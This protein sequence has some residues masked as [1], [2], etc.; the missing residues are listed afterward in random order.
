MT[1]LSV[2]RDVCATVG[3]LVPSSVFTNITGN[4]TMIEMA[5]L[6]NDM[7]QRIAFETRDWSKL[8]ATV[9]YTGDGVTTAFD[10]PVNYKRMLLT[11][12]VWKSTTA[13]YPMR[14]IPDLDQWLQRR[15]LDNYDPYGEWTIVGNQ[16]FI[17]P[18]MAGPISSNPA[19]T[20]YFAYLRNG[21]VNLTSGGFGDRFVADTDS[22]VLDERLLKL[23]MIW[24]WKAHKGSPYN[25]DM[26]NYET[27]LGYVSRSDG[28][29]PIIIGRQPMPSSTRVAYPYPTP[30]APP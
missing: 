30:I 27:A 6:A 14:F 5:N 11:S 19:I 17:V 2:V 23:G 29:A 9:T 1:I 4:R 13:L 24:Q 26:G 21:C 12:N 18:V 20:A 28:P 10:L 8:K 16:I 15:A 7:A 3:V 22:F 25:E